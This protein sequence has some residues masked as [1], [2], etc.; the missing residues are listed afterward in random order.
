MSRQRFKTYP[1][2]RPLAFVYGLVTDVRNR[3]FDT[4][5]IETRCFDLA[6]ISV[7]NISVGG[8]G[9]TPMC[10]YLLNLLKKNG[11][12]PALLSRG[13]GRKTKGF[14]EV[15]SRSTSAE[16]GDE[17]LELFHK[18]GGSVEVC[19]CE[20]RCQGA[21]KM[22]S[23]GKAI[24]SLVLDDAFQHRYI[25]R[26]LDIVLTDYNRLYTRDKVMPEGLL[27][28]RSEGAERAD[29]IVVTK[30]DEGLKRETADR[31]VEELN[32]LPHQRVFFTAIGYERVE[33]PFREADRLVNGTNTDAQICRLDALK[34]L[35]FTGIAKPD[36]LIEYYKKR[37]RQVNVLRFGDHHDYSSREMEMIVREAHNADIVITTDK[38]W[39]RIS[40]KTP[41][42]LKSKLLIQHIGV[43]FLFDGQREFDNLILETIKRKIFHKS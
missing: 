38:D 21:E 5:R 37:Y 24:G 15:T 40:N 43:K 23:D 11:C 34:M 36:P 6:V 39:Q 30:C 3:L 25:G 29:I 35:I 8:T 2:L 20:N 19:V 13:Y 22:L 1:F 41:D 7:G 33:N 12:K 14:V 27:R 17:P 42:M 10:G 9:K 28:E 4:G 31:I 32:P 18:F 26:N 16:V